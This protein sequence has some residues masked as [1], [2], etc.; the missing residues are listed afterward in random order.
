VELDNVCDQVEAV[1]IIF[2]ITPNKNREEFVER[3][4]LHKTFSEITS[5]GFPR[6]S[7]IFLCYLLGSR[8]PKLFPRVHGAKNVEGSKGGGAFEILADEKTPLDV[9]RLE[10]SL[11]V[12]DFDLPFVQM[13]KW[14][15]QG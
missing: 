1:A 3:H 11:P 8:E 7:R 14:H 10:L 4:H 2:R 15:V 6:E 13:T 5:K 12:L 9:N